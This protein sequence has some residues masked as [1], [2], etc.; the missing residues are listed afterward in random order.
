MNNETLRG[1]RC[2]KFLYSDVHDESMSTLN[3]G[4]KFHTIYARNI[5]PFSLRN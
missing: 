5:D 1:R 3:F 4:E 2:I